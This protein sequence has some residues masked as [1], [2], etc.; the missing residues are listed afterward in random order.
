MDASGRFLACRR[1]PH[2]SLGD[3]WEFPGGKL[4]PGESP[5][6]ALVRELREELQITVEILGDMPDVFHAYPNFSVRLIPRLCRILQGEPQPTEHTALRWCQPG[7]A[8]LLEWAPA[9]LPILER[10]EGRFGTDP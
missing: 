7:E 6:A 9:D 2:K 8:R 4:E 3:L 10:L 1:P 5:E